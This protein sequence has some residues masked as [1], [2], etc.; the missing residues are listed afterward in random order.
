S[1]SVTSLLVM[2]AERF[3]A[4][5]KLSTYENSSTK[6]A[7]K[8]VL[9]HLL[10]TCLGVMADY[11]MYNFPTRVAHCIVVSVDGRAIHDTIQAALFYSELFTIFF[12]T[13]LLRRNERVQASEASLNKTLTERYQLSENIRVL[14]ILLPVVMF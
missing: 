4:F 10:L 11:S 8:F 5:R 13:K 3:Q 14:R 9:I 12:Y 6:N 2:S 7:M 1:G